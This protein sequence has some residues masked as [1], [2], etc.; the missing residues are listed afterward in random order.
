MDL[1]TMNHGTLL[2]HF[3]L[4]NITKKAINEQQT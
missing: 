2:G 1:F 3:S 4:H